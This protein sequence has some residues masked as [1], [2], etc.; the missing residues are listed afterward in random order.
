MRAAVFERFREIRVHASPSWD[1][2]QVDSIFFWF[3]RYDGDLDFEGKNWGDLL[4]GW[5]TL[6]PATGRFKS[7]EGQVVTLQDMNAG[8]YVDSDPLD[9]DHLSTGSS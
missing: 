7:V 9:L 2:L 6:V 5:L 1:A 3:V 4:K 8:E